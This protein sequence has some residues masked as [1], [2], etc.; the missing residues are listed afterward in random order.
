LTKNNTILLKAGFIMAK[1]LYEIHN[2]AENNLPFIYHEFTINR[3][4]SGKYSNW[5][6]NLELI[7]HKD[8]EGYA[9]IDAAKQNITDRGIIIINSNDIHSI[10]SE[11]FFS[12]DCLII[13]NEFCKT[14][15]IDVTKIRFTERSSNESLLRI[16]DEAVALIKK[17]RTSPD[18][19]D[20]PKIRNLLLSIMIY[21][22]ESCK[23]ENGLPKD[24]YASD[25]VKEIILYIQNNISSPMTLDDISSQIKMSKYYLC[26]EFKHLTGKTIFEFIN[27]LRCKEAK[28]K[29]K[30]GMPIS[31]AAFSVG[32]ENLSYFAKKFKETMGKLPS[33]YKKKDKASTLQNI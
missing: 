29:I 9:L 30:D 20:I 8:G 10:H 3:G 21:L 24:S 17:N 18:Y 33:D 2:L 14:N 26:R 27:I 11:T 16:F 31:E 1:S 6:E 19:M 32:Y 4:S 5:H 23:E 22:C 28:E 7:R 25:R 15:G 12:Y 13:D